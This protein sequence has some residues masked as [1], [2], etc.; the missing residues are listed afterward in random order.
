[1]SCRKLITTLYVLS[2]VGLAPLG[3]A[4]RA[5]APAIA[6]ED[7][8]VL[9]RTST[10]LRSTRGSGFLIGDGSWVVTA[11]HVVSADLGKGRRVWDRTA[12]VYTAWTGRPYEAKVVGV[13]GVADIA[14]LR[15]PQAGLPALPVEGLDLKDAATAARALENRPLRLYG[16]PL[17][18]GEDTVAALAKPEHNDTRLRGISK[19]GETSLAVLNACPDAQPGWSGGPV[20]SA[21]RGTVVSV[22]HSL[23]REKGAETGLPA[24]SVAGYLGDLLR[25]S[26]QADL[27]PFTRAGAPS[28]QRP[29]DAKERMAHEMRSLSWSAVGNWKKAEEEHREI[30]K[31]SPQDALARVELGKLLLEQQKFETA[32]TELREAVRL[33]PRSLLANLY[34]GRALHLN[35]DPKGAAAALLAAQEISPEEVEPRLALAQV[36][37]ENQKPAE[38]EAALRAALKTS[39]EH[40]GALLRLGN[41]LIRNGKEGEGLKILAE[42]S[43]LAASDPGLSTIALAYARALD[44]GRKVSQ[45]EG[46]YR[47]VLKIDP[48]NEQAHYYLTLLYLRANRIDDAQVQLN[49]AIVLPKLSEPMLQA[50]RALQLRINEKGTGS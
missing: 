36:H 7:A 48:Q 19:R 33:A 30:V 44:K 18:Y 45:A 31:G 28:V 27:A 39:P 14:L 21:D 24:A 15:L 6:P 16:F 46:A 41:L 43:E 37:E 23:Y 25:Q 47:Q 2:A 29:A 35:Y 34:L 8:I 40:P 12:L 38:A 13:D 5:Q 1:M 4:V 49:A 17:T 26:G 42:A 11:S 10:S 32:L 50:L 3:R 22:F 20:V 9:I